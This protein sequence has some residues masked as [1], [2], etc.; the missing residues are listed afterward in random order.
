MRRTGTTT[1]DVLGSGRQS[2]CM[3]TAS[4]AASVRTSSPVPRA[5]C[6]AAKRSA[7]PMAA[8]DVSSVTT[9]HALRSSNVPLSKLSSTRRYTCVVGLYVHHTLR[10][11][12]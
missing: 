8:A 10:Y 2:V 11:T 9:G 1:A 6:A 7:R 12:R 3:S 4:A 5:S